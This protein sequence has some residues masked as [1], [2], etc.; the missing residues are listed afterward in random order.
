[1]MTEETKQVVQSS[2][3]QFEKLMD[4]TRHPVNPDDLTLVINRII[5]EL[6]KAIYSNMMILRDRCIAEPFT[7]ENDINDKLFKTKHLEW[8]INNNE[9]I[10]LFQIGKILHDTDNKAKFKIFHVYTET[11][12]FVDVEFDRDD[13]ICTM[14][15]NIKPITDINEKWLS[16]L[17]HKLESVEDRYAEYMEMSD[18]K[19]SLLDL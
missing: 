15:Y 19:K 1:M 7:K 10:T 8:I 11:E 14:R 12:F 18:S 16:R 2:I 17:N 9:L 3:T 13:Y 6:S 4:Y 5:P